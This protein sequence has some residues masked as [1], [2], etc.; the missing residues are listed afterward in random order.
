MDDIKH[1]KLKY[2]E[3]DIASCS[4][5]NRVTIFRFQWKGNV[6]NG[7]INWKNNGL[8][9]RIHPTQK[10]VQ[11]YQWLLQNYAKQGDRI[12]DTHVGSASSL[13]AFEKEGF[14]YV[15]FELKDYF[16]D[17]NKR[18]KQA[19]IT[20]IDLFKEPKK[21]NGVRENEEFVF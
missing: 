3:A 19:R 21:S 18:L 8:N 20:T 5:Q 11:L 7:K 1:T 10:P 14:D 9:G 17:A 12:L 16:R 15:G 2:S 6:Q 4:M 13:I